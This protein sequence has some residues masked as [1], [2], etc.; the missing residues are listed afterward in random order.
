MENDLF[1]EAVKEPETMDLVVKEFNLGTLATNAEN[2]RATVKH[3]LEYYKWKTY[4]D[5][6]IQIARDDRA[7][8]NKSASTLNAAKIELKKKWLKPFEDNFENII[9]EA[10]KDIKT[11]STV[12]DTGIKTQEEKDKQKKKADIETFFT[13][14]NCEHFQLT[15]IFSPAWLNKTYKMKDIEAEI[16]AKIEKVKSDLAI[17][18]RM[19]EPEAKAHYLTSLNLEAAIA[20]ADR[21]KANRERLAAIKK[22]QDEK[23]AAR[24]AE[25]AKR[26]SEMVIEEMPEPEFIVPGVQPD[27]PWPKPPAKPEPENSTET[28]QSPV[29]EPIQFYARTFKIYATK[30]NIIAV[31]RF[32]DDNGIQWTRID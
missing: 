15:Q 13:S 6:E 11:V 24:L 9:D 18:D 28:V 5:D 22:A 4:T 29:V 25:I 12:V 17:L 14:L 1:G 10:V 30:E 8:L 19:G 3:K 32:M 2:I 7:M 21:I 23:E 26:E 31:S 20:E 16:T 27:R